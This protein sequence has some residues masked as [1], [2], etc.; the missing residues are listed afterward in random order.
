MRDDLF[1]LEG[2]TIVVTGGSGQIGF[3]LVRRLP[4][5]GAKAVVGVRDC[6]RFERMIDELGRDFGELRPVAHPIDIS[7]ADSITAFFDV[8]AEEHGPIH[9]FVNNA[10]PRRHGMTPKF[11]EIEP[12]A[13]YKDL[14]DHAGGYFLCAQAAAEYMKANRQGVIVNIGSL[15][16]LVAPDF[17]IYDGTQ[18][19]SPGQ[20]ALIKGGI[21]SFTRYLSSFLAEYGIRVN[22]LSPGGILNEDIQDPIFI[23]A[24]EKHTPLKRMARPDDIC[25]PIIFL[26]SDASKYMTGTVI[27]VDGGWSA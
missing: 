27:P 14:C 22:C 18:M 7:D 8:V 15:Y 20:Y 4:A 1:S 23:K 6:T 26:L 10:W 19:T 24:Y 16:G 9:G 17:S 12:Q 5:Y 25:G 11:G 2:K 13:L 3:E 21:H